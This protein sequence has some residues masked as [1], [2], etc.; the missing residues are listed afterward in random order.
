MRA[1]A[2]ILL[3]MPMVAPLHAAVYCVAV[4]PHSR[5]LDYCCRCCVSQDSFTLLSFVRFSRPEALRTKGSS[6]QLP[7]RLPLHIWSR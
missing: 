6:A 7:H 2:Y 4:C 5:R 3:Y 1:E